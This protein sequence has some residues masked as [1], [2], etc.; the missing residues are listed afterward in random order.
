[1]TSQT[2]AS[3]LAG[4]I[5]SDFRQADNRLVFVEFG[6]LLSELRLA[7][8]A[9]VVSSG[10]A[11]LRGTW[12]FDFDRGVEVAVDGTGDVWWEQLTS[13][14][15][16]MVPMGG[17]GLVNLGAV[18]FT[19]LGYTQLA[20][21]PYAATPIPG[22]DDSTN[23]LVVGDVF[24]VRTNAG[25]LA[26]VKVLAYGYNL[27]I[28][29]VTYAPTSG[30][31]QL[32]SGYGNL[33]A[34][35]VFADEQHALVSE[36]SGRILQV[37]LASAD[38]SAPTT[39]VLVSG[40]VAPHQIALDEPAHLAYVVEYDPAGGRLLRIDLTSN[41]WSIVATG[42]LGAVGLALDAASGTAYVT[43]QTRGGGQLTRVRL[44]D[45]RQDPVASGLGA[46]FMLTWADDAHSALYT[47]QRDPQNDVALVVI[48]TG[49]VRTVVTDVPV[50]PSSVALATPSSLLVCS[51]TEISR[52]ELSPYAASG[53]VL[54]G[55]G[56]IPADKVSGGLATTDPGYFFPVTNAPFGGT[57]PVMVN[58]LGARSV[59]ARYYT[60]EVD[61][62]PVITPFA[63][64][65]WV[66]GS[67]TLTTTTP[68]ATRFFPV[69]S[70]A[71]L[72]YTA[73]LG[74][75]AATGDLPDGLHRITIRLFASASAASE[76]GSGTD[77]GRFVDVL[78]HNR[79][80]RAIIEHIHKDGIEVGPC[81]LV[82]TSGAGTGGFTFTV[83]ADSPDGYLSSWA[84]WSQW[85]A[86]A[87]AMIASDGYA[88][89]APG[90]WVGVTSVTVPPGG[91]D[92]A[93]PGDP[94]S[95]N[96][97]HGFT[98]EA[99]DRT[100][101]GWSALYRSSMSVFLTILP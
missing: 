67:F 89:H 17:A 47:T 9:R 85:G 91:W 25:R 21:L 70:A 68:V 35:A 41:A 39:G 48:A 3:G 32:G 46:P 24:A 86:N 74:Y 90:P 34:V 18:N 54:L 12:L 59:G 30:Y 65:K 37:D 4:A 13:V 44:S 56:H 66:A 43:E 26:K 78:V 2:L 62:L 77:A 40:L 36:R 87:S 49:E 14:A 97:A 27:Q 28:R 38:A 81:A 55:I 58:H 84:L 10:T 61:G 63:D 53:P 1:M 96:C 93:V 88:A 57:L 51:N 75:F 79:P 50:R 83:T 82:H 101:N 7:P 73:S 76:I 15:R 99:W 23:Q 5:G 60:V 52:V 8:G 42:L 19:A 69:R 33:E 98:L 64:Y 29:W 22:S 20:A 100:T 16:A 95:V 71:D 45:G 80:P 72:W 31:R 94:S 11:T 6:G 92:A